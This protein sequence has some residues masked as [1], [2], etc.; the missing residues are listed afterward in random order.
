M[1]AINLCFWL[2]F[3]I[4]P[5]RNAHFFDAMAYLERTESNLMSIFKDFS[6][7]PTQA[8]AR[9]KEIVTDRCVVADCT[10]PP[11]MIS[12]GCVHCEQRWHDADTYIFHEC[13]I[14][15]SDQSLR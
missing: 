11:D 14:D 1:H 2:I 12:F 6:L 15:K 10:F 9:L 5:L 4:V 7:E 8:M 13:G 3:V